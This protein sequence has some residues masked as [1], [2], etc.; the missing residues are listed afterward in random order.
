MTEISQTLDQTGE[1]VR[2]LITL[3]KTLKSH[4]K[5][6]D[7]LGFQGSIMQT[8]LNLDKIDSLCKAK[9][10]STFILSTRRLLE[11]LIACVSEFQRSG[12]A[13]QATNEFVTRARLALSFFP[14]RFRVTT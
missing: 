12:S 5:F 3:F 2:H 13:E 1:L 14:S 7:R 10:A 6:F 11:S 9:E 8:G 4:P